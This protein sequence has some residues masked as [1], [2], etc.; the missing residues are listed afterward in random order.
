MQL[1]QKYTD[2]I[3]TE[4][5]H[6]LGLANSMAIPKIVKIVVNVG[7]GEAVSDKKILQSMGEQIALIT[8]QK[9]LITKAKKAIATYKLRAGMPIGLK[10]TL[11]GK[12]MYHF[13]EKFIGI[14]LPR[15]RDFR[16]VKASGFDRHGNLSIGFS[17]M[18]VFPEVNYQS[19]DRVRGFE[20]TV[21][22]TA[23]NK[24]EGKL[25]LE[26]LGLPFEKQVQH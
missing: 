3:K 16:G 15:V 6:E 11:R 13:L 14:T 7:L 2:K 18:T 5:G 21:V 24:D 26:K 12:R 10:V 17:E 9:P 4:L 22:T 25:L 20:I 23:K 19:L 1:Q 8:G